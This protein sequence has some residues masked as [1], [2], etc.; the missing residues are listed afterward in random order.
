[1][2]EVDFWPNGLVVRTGLKSELWAITSWTDPRPQRLAD[3]VGVGLTSPPTSMVV[4]A[5]EDKCE[6]LLAT[7]QGSIIVVD[8]AQAQDQLL[9]SGPF[10]RMSLS[11]SGALLAAFNDDG[12]LHL[13]STDFKSCL[14]KFSTGS[15]LAPLQMVWVGEEALVLAWEG[16]LLLV[17]LLGDFVKFSMDEPF[18]LVPEFDGARIVTG[19]ACEWLA[20]VAD[21][22]EAVFKIGSTTPAAQLFD[23]QEAFEHGNARADDNLRA[24]AQG[25]GSGSG[26]SSGGN[27]L[28]TAID[29]C[30]HAAAH[31]F[32]YE[33]QRSLLKAASY[34]KLV[35]ASFKSDKFVDMCRTLRVLNAVRDPAVGMP[36]S[37]AQYQK[38][39]A[40]VLVD[41]LVA[42]HLHLLA[43]RV[44]EYLRI[45]PERVLVHWACVKIRCCED[46]SDARL[47]EMIVDKLS[48]CPG[49]SFARIAS[50]AFR[51]GRRSLAT[52]LLEFEPLASDQVPLLM[53]MKEDELALT[54]AV[55]SGD[56]DLVHLA[57]LHLRKHRKQR[58]FFALI[59][60]KPLARDLFIAYC[61]QADLPALK[62][63]LV[64][65]GRSAAV[66]A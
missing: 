47:G 32:D 10:A 58:D 5:N 42:R 19:V 15:K 30:L 6:V 17:G 46:L 63:S 48:L 23:A 31:E 59:K 45:H 66:L 41:R 7:A 61:K 34:G 24:L 35:C 36:L 29:Q 49:I 8:A 57:L 56:T 33:V 55:A 3:A 9:A 14:S 22:T 50:T 27:A 37:Y 16:M 44:C 21:A 60:D 53:S 39:E 62:V 52:L 20:R 26:S 38:L 40:E 2:A 28:K 25:D 65:C 12:T 51:Y 1:M 64:Q 43:L 54:K 11:P 13:M 18:V 4:L